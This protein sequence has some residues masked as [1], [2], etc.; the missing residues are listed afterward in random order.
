MKTFLLVGTAAAMGLASPAFSAANLVTNGDFETGSFSG[1]SQ[2]MAGGDTDPVVI[3][4][5]STDGYPDGAFGEP[6]G[7]NPNGG[8][9]YLAYF[10]S[11]TA[12]PD[13]LSQTINGLVSGTKYNISFDYYVPQNGFD[14]PYDATLSLGLGDLSE[15]PIFT[16]S[17]A[18]LAAG[19]VAQ[20]LH[21]STIWEA[22][23]DGSI[24]LNFQF[25][26]LG[27]TA[28]DFGLDNVSMT[29]VPEPAT[30]ALLIA[31]F[32]LVG[33]SMRRRRTTIS[34]A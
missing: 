32:A 12:S 10:S 26:G 21:F 19:D 27:V 18:D 13:T 24:D 33:I 6:I 15:A 34:F 9:V 1:W 30:W 20:W 29:A 31:G 16:L 28:A 7:V 14:N 23:A 8:G 25:T 17:T 5:G 22:T 2:T 4:Y 3:K 11:D